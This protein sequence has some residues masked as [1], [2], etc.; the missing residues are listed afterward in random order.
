M[1][2]STT[3]APAYTHTHTQVNHLNEIHGMLVVV[4]DRTRAT[5]RRAVHIALLQRDGA[6]RPVSFRPDLLPHPLHHSAC[7]VPLTGVNS[8]ALCCRKTTVPESILK[9]RKAVEKSRAE[10]TAA[11]LATRKANLAKRK[12]IF[13]RAEQYVKE[14]RQIERQEIELK[15]KAKMDNG[16]YVAPEAKLAFVIRIK[17]YVCT[18]ISRG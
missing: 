11:Q 1:V 13:K 15:R 6:A 8:S 7:P 4:G 5:W 2:P 14:Y 18:W 3:L 16:F 12:V 9:K 10:R 17:G